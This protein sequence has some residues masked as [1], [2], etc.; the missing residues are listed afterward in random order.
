L[1]VQVLWKAWRKKATDGLRPVLS[2]LPDGLFSYQKIPMWVFLEGI[3]MEN[4]AIF[5][6]HLVYLRP[7][8]IRYGNMDRLRVFGIFSPFWYV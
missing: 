1:A 2:G 8:G 6:E 7:F 3:G 5:Y 4:A